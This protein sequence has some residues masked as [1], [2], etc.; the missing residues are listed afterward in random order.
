MVG[1]ENRKSRAGLSSKGNAAMLPPQPKYP[2]VDPLSDI[3]NV[4]SCIDG[5]KICGGKRTG[6][7]ESDSPNRIRVGESVLA[8]LG[9]EAECYVSSITNRLFETETHAVSS[10]GFMN[11][12]V[13]INSRMRAILVDWLVEVHKGFSLK[14]GTLFLSINLLD[15]YLS[16][17]KN[18]KRQSLQLVGAVAL[19]VAAKFEEI[20]PPPVKRLVYMC[21]NAYSKQQFLDFE[22]SFLAKLGFK[23][24]VPTPADFVHYVSRACGL[25]AVRSEL[26]FYSLELALLDGKCSRYEPS[27]LAAAALLVSGEVAGLSQPW[28]DHMVSAARW[29]LPALVEPAAEL[30]ALLASAPTSQLKAVRKKYSMQAHS[31][32]ALAVHSRSARLNGAR[33]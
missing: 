31:S 7:M 15:R 21:D 10:K 6:T 8:S 27:M 14:R 28:P 17:V 26:A 13:D 23:I 25:A 20:C 1:V 4:A 29:S 12:H 19:L 30:R 2:A 16:K 33:Q 3:T 5:N 9:E 32:V 24:L 11:G 18:V 22:C